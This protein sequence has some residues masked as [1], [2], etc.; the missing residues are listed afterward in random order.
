MI[1]KILRN[2]KNAIIVDSKI[3]IIGHNCKIALD[4]APVIELII[5]VD[6]FIINII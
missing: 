6:K 3:A 1:N 4:T 2:T 5:S